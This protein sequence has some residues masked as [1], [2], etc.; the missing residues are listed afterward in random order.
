MPQ[1]LKQM[2]QGM[3]FEEALKKEFVSPA[4]RLERDWKRW[5]LRFF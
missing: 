4:E 1:L 3:S 5:L 2:A